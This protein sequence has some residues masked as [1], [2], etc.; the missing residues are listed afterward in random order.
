MLKIKANRGFTLIELMITVAIVAIVASIAYPSYTRQV[1]KSRRADAG[2]ALMQ[3]A[4]A[5]ERQF[6]MSNAYNKD[7]AGTAVTT[8][9]PPASLC[10]TVR[11]AGDSNKCNWPLA[12]ADKKMYE[13]TIS[14]LTATSYTLSAAPI[15]GAAQASDSCGTLTLTS[16][17]VKSP[18]TS[19]CW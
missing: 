4:N 8:G 17:G 10:P 1:Q 11:D 2:G 16:A 19:G 12:G 13:L 6:T 5:M 18:S 9:T 7:A 14:A 15:A 3:M